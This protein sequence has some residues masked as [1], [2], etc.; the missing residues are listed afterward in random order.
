MISEERL[1][2]ALEEYDE[3]LMAAL[4]DPGECDHRFS[5]RF[6]QKMRKLFRR[7]K[8]PVAYKALQRAACVLLA[9]LAL[10]GGIIAFNPDVRAAVVDWV[11]EQFGHFSHYYHAGEIT[12]PPAERA[13]YE[14]SWLPEGY[15]LLDTIPEED[16]ESSFYIN[17][18]GQL[19]KFFYY[20]ETEYGPYIKGDEHI[21]KTAT[22]GNYTA[23]IYLSLNADNG[24][25]IV[26]VDP[27]SGV[28]FHIS[29]TVSEDELIQLA[30]SVIEKN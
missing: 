26:W 4:P 15:V 13:Q 20:Y 8:H 25:V 17:A 14:L 10:F 7:A 27:E 1:R 16:C 30:A 12:H 21:H 11:R 5:P 23:D 2:L 6:Q 19:L 3:A 28:L 9:L 22:V 24:S 18:S 29:A